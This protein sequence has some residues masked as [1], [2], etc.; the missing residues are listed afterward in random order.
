[1]PLTSAAIRAPAAHRFRPGMVSPLPQRRSI[2]IRS[3]LPED[4]QTLADLGAEAFTAAHQ[5]A[6]PPA[7]LADLTARF[8]DQAHL[9]GL[10]AHSHISTL[11]AVAGQRVVGMACLD[12]IHQPDLLRYI[13][14]VELCRFYLRT[15]WTGQGIGSALLSHALDEAAR[16]GYAACGLRVWQGN[17]RAIALY[18]RWGFEVV[19]ADLYRVGEARVPLLFMV[20]LLMPAKEAA[21][22]PDEGVRAAAT[23]TAWGG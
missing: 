1:M 6:M 14:A 19:A 15:G 2:L 23:V 12:P 7:A 5:S 3:A 4:T 17:Q 8:W 9:A 10:I 13:G 21:R 18:E 22:Q 20:R 16:R 11:V